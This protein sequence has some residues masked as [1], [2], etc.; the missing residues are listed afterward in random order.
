[1]T[2]LETIQNNPEQV[3]EDEEQ[4]KS[5]IQNPEYTIELLKALNVYDLTVS[6]E[7]TPVLLVRPL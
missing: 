6:I 2:L 4:L 3:L 5:L 7:S 1:M